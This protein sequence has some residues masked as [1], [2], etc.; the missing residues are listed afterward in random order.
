MASLARVERVVFDLGGVFFRWEPLVLLQEVF[1]QAAPDAAAAV[2]LAER[3]FQT[4]DPCSDWAQFDLGQVEPQTLARKIA[5][6]TGLKEADLLALMAAIPA[7]MSVHSGTV[8]IL[9]ALHGQGL[10]VYFLSNMPHGYADML[11]RGHPFFSLFTDG[12]F[13]AHVAQ[14]KP[15]AAIYA[16]ADR[17]F[18]SAG[19]GTL[20]IDDVPRNIHAAER[21]GWRGLLFTD[22]EQCQRA[23]QAQGVLPAATPVL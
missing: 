21:H 9:R 4:F 14:I 11:V 16:T 17:R 22:A 19:D 13:S 15:D 12:I 23:L 3:I 10:P 5:R 8:A 18:G 6:R 1:P 7:H 2:G 20:F